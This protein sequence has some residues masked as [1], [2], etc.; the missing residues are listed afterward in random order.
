[1]PKLQAKD[2]TYIRFATEEEISRNMPLE[3]NP[4]PDTTIRVLMLY[5]GLDE[6]ESVTEQLL[7]K[8]ERTGYIVVEWGGTK[9]K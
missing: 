1:M 5:K 8:V 9:I 3:I 4:K 6:A 2:Y 7:T